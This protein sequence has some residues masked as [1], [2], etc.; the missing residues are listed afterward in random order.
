MGKQR[1]EHPVVGTWPLDDEVI[2]FRIFGTDETYELSSR[3]RVRTIG[4]SSKCDLRIR[5]LS[6]RVAAQHARLVRRGSQWTIRASD[7]AA[8]LCS[9]HVPLREGPLIPGINIGLGAVKLIAESR[10]SQALHRYLAWL[11]GFGAQHR[12]QIDRALGTVLRAASG[13]GAL[14]LC[15]QEDLIAV[16]RRLHW[17][18]LG[19]RPFIVCDPR[20]V[21]RSADIRSASNIDEPMAALAAAAGGS[22]CVLTSRLPRNFNP[23]FEHWRRSATRVQLILCGRTADRILAMTAEP[24]VVTPLTLRSRDRFRI[25]DEI[26]EDVVAALGVHAP[27]LSAADRR[28]ILQHDGGAVPD[29]EKATLRVAA[30]RSQATLS[31]AA[32]Q[33]GM[34]PISLFRWATARGLLQRKLE[35]GHARGV[36]GRR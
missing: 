27:P 19:D 34:A 32:K 9:D 16:A 28:L 17:H 25:L 4:T 33:L 18:T 5:D 35:E 20:R 12:V 24:L 21:R 13:L 29:L 15:G 3:P 30:L 6:G 8:G 23:V 31:G 2:R 10:R 22:L 36:N 11:I 26:A 1:Q 14:S 7:D